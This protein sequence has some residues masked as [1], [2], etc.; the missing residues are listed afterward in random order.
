MLDMDRNIR[1]IRKVTP[2]GH[3]LEAFDRFICE[4]HVVRACRGVV[5]SVMR[6][7]SIVNS[8]EAQLC[9]QSDDPRIAGLRKHNASMVSPGRIA[10]VSVKPSRKD[11]VIRTLTLV[12]FVGIGLVLA[13][14]ED[15]VTNL[16][17][18]TADF[19]I[20]ERI[21]YHNGRVLCANA[22]VD[23]QYFRRR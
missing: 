18:S 2:V 19:D 12:A 1:I 5:A 10:A 23:N 3:R 20:V 7:D 13:H 16:C 21:G 4:A 9:V 14:K 17:N 22:I 11:L 6:V 15:V 8:Q